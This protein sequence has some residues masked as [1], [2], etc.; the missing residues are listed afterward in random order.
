MKRFKVTPFLKGNQDEIYTTHFNFSSKIP[1]DTLK[2]AYIRHNSLIHSQN[3]RIH[4]YST[5]KKAGLQNSQNS[6]IELSRRDMNNSVLK[7]KYGDYRGF[8]QG[9]IRN[10]NSL[11][12][13]RNLSEMKKSVG[14][15]SRFQSPLNKKYGETKPKVGSGL[16]L[17]SFKPRFPQHNIYTRKQNKHVRYVNKE[18][19]DQNR[20]DNHPGPG[21]RMNI[22]GDF[23]GSKKPPSKGKLPPKSRR[24]PRQSS[25]SRTAVGNEDAPVDECTSTIN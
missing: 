25:Q 19:L 22:G 16:T 24:P 10:N 17:K 13:H 21:P 14:L 15:N 11:T 4:G 12:G 5:P 8:R 6:N 3:S 7:S 2:N 9:S 20:P 18:N 23:K 1:S